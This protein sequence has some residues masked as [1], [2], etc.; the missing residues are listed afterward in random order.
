[1]LFSQEGK[2]LVRN[3][4]SNS[5]ANA[6]IQIK[7]YSQSLV[8]PDGV[9]IYR[10]G[11]GSQLWQKLNTTPVRVQRRASADMLQRDED[12]EAFLEMAQNINSTSENGFLLLNLFIKS[13][14]SEDLSKVIGIHWDDETASWGESYQYK[15]T[16][17]S[18]SREEDVGVSEEIAVGTYQADK[19]VKGFEA[20]LDSAIVK[21]TW[22]AE[23]G[24]FYGTNIFRRDA[25][26]TTWVKLNKN[27]IVLSEAPGAAPESTVMFQDTQV[28]EGNTYQYKI[29][30]LDFFGAETEESKAVIVEIED[31]TPPP[32][33]Y[34][35]SKKVSNQVVQLT[36]VIRETDDIKGFYV[37]RSIKSEGP[38]IK[39]N[40]VPFERTNYSFSDS[41][42]VGFY[43]Y[44]VSS[45]DLAGNE[46]PSN[47]IL[48]EVQDTT[49]PAPPSQLM[50][51]SDTGKVVL[52]WKQNMEAD[53]AGYHVFRTS[54]DSISSFLLVNSTPLKD[55][56]YTQVLPSNVGNTFSF[57]VVAVDTSFN[58]SRPSAV[59][60]VKLPDVTA[61]VQPFI[62]SLRQREDSVLIEWLPNPET[63]LKGYRLRRMQ[64]ESLDSLIEVNLPIN[65]T[66]YVDWLPERGK[67]RYD[68][69]AIDTSGNKSPVSIVH[70]VTFSQQLAGD[71]LKLEANYSRRKKRLQLEWVVERGKFEGF[72]V[73]KKDEKDIWRPVSGLQPALKFEQKDVDEK[74]K[75]IY[76]VRAYS[77]S[78]D[79]V[80]S[81]EV[82]VKKGR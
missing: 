31:I 77:R 24:R 17:F 75:L 28:K 74:Q 1:M 38:F 51:K 50:A 57:H 81:P 37:Y 5:E 47:P 23:E 15:V 7:W 76:Q 48:V 82:T 10:R 41:V 40:E 30:G 72:V 73:F 71:F 18:G 16:R 39:L 32:T 13:F 22:Q 54:A 79:V 21:M 25:I 70:H 61:P 29:T 33:P 59:V 34:G 27:P 45:T 44:Y 56:T 19:P 9:N 20:V 36:W 4:V 69:T 12:I 78:G 49:P 26:D 46:S 14:Q 67:Y 55:T 64:G 6:K 80:L 62:S 8:Y 2:I 66:R 11:N 42:S 35:L 58:R 60:A 53:L 3:G 52:L 63:D 68:L 65:A 43:Y